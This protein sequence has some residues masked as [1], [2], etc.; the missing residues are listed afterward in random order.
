MSERTL[1]FNVKGSVTK[2][3]ATVDVTVTSGNNEDFKLAVYAY[4][5]MVQDLRGRGY[6]VTSDPEKRQK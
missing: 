1:T 4:D 3:E 6:T 2:N 5:A